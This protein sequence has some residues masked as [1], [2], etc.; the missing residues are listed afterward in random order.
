MHLG[1]KQTN[2]IPM[3]VGIRMRWRMRYLHFIS[4]LKSFEHTLH[5]RISLEFEELT[6]S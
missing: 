6:L 2:E 5:E 1:L 4:F 3:F